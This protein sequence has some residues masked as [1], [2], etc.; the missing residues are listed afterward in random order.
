MD[1]ATGTRDMAQATTRT[2]GRRSGRRAARGAQAVVVMAV[3]GVS[4]ARVMAAPAE[5]LGG[6]APSGPTAH[7]NY[8]IDA[9][10]RVDRLTVQRSPDDGEVTAAVE[11]RD[12]GGQVLSAATV[13]LTGATV[14]VPL[15]S[16]IDPARIAVVSLHV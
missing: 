10:G 1:R 9:A 11:L 2:V 3:L 14:V 16:A 6:A 12:A 15:S 8:G 13:H 4:S 5:P 7:L